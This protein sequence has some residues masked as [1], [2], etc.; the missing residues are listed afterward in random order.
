[1]D[2]LHPSALPAVMQCPGTLFLVAYSTIVSRWVALD[3]DS[4]I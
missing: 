2:S 1:M 3:K 4:I